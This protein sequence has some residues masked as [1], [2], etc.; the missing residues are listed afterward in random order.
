MDKLGLSVDEVLSTTRAVRK[1]LDFDRPVETEV[2]NECIE[3]A[4]QSPTGSNSQAWQWLVV[5]DAD[6]R[7]AIADL[8]K[9]GWAQYMNMEGNVETAYAGDDASRVAQQARVQS[10]AEYL[11]ENFEK[12]PVMLIPCLPGRLDG[13]PAIVSASM[14]GS[15]LPG[16][17]SFMLAARER[18]LGT[19]WTTIHLMFEEQAAEILEVPYAE[20]QQCALITA[21]YSLGTDFKPAT[22]PPLD[23]VVRWNSW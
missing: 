14:L 7:A 12:V 6:K 19:A 22:R 15:I 21:G 4:I 10:S 11:A 20:V 9:Q 8:Y 1:R 17:W 16:A 23:T 5:T 2:I 13:M 18:G 3:A